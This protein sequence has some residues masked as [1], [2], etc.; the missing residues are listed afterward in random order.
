M[1]VNLKRVLQSFF[2][3]QKREMTRKLDKGEIIFIILGLLIAF[4]LVLIFYSV[5][6]LKRIA[7]A[8]PYMVK[9]IFFLIIAIVGFSYVFM[10]KL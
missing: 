2:A 9:I 10:K 1:K 4:L 8:Y 5:P 7:D 6:G 3:N